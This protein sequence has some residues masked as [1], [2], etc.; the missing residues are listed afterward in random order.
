MW[1]LNEVN[2]NYS[3]VIAIAFEI[4]A[5]STFDIDNI[6]L[7][8]GPG[9]GVALNIQS[10]GVV[11]FEDIGMAPLGPPNNN[12]GVS[13]NFNDQN[14]VFRYGGNGMLSLTVNADGTLSFSSSSGGTIYSI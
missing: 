7:R 4:T 1:Q 10:L 8:V 11:I 9:R 6:P 5:N 2:N 13:I 12:W 14:W 3:E